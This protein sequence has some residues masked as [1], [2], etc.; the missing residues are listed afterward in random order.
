MNW[1]QFFKYFLIAFAAFMI[2]CIPIQVIASKAANARLFS[3]TNEEGEEVVDLASLMDQSL[4][5]PDS[6]FFQAFK[7]KKRVN[8]LF[9]GINTGLTDTIMLASFDMEAK[10]VD[11]ISIPRDTYYERRGYNS[12]AERKIN[13]AYRGDVV[14]TANAVSDVLMGIPIHYYAIIDYDGIIKIVDSMGGVTVNVPF[15]MRYRD[16]KDTPPLYIDIP[17]GEQTLTGEQAMQFI[18]FR[19]GSPGYPG[20][21]EGDIGRVK[22]QQEFMKAAFKQAL[23]LKNLPGVVS[24][25][26]DNVQ[27][28]IDLGTAVNIGLQAVGMDAEAVSTYT[29]PGHGDPDPPYYWYSEKDGI[30]EML[31]EIYSIEPATES[32]VTAGG[33][34]DEA[35]KE[36]PGLW[37]RIKS[38][39]PF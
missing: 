9:L 23:S 37:E 17:E 24:T 2:I 36:K 21:P 10:H 30:E 20:Y 3:T 28:N 18:R 5:D 35:P 12:D 33:I 34:E 16:P 29:L 6:K 26:F 11:L 7:E 13:A 32:A 31:T 39:L 19:K 38:W 14:N 1:K 27:S 4:V 22:T 8:F 25:V 15:H